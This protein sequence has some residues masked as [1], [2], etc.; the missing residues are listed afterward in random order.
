MPCY[1]INCRIGFM[2]FRQIV[3][4][5]VF[6]I[7]SSVVMAQDGENYIIARAPQ[8]SVL[9]L[10]AAWK[11]FIDY[12]NRT[13]SLHFELK[14]YGDRTSFESDIVAGIPDFIFGNPGYAVVAH[15][16]HGY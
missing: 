12:L 11:P 13:L 16:L 7:F 4:L 15:H 10:E 14:L 8:S 3:A 5:L 6:Y 9:L 2:S 1:I